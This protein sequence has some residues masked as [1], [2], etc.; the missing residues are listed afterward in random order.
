[1]NGIRLKSNS[2]GR[3]VIIYV[4]GRRIESYEGETV[5]A[6]LFADG[7]LR[8]HDSGNEKS[9]RGFFCGMGICYECLVTV[10][11]RANQRACQV[12]VEDQMEI[13][14]DEE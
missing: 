9:P 14:I 13:F 8:L 6:A 4:N 12:L 1:M 2:K 5:H 11:G 3:S 7:I 10:N